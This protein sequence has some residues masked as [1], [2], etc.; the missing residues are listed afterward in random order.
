MKKFM[1]FIICFCLMGFGQILASEKATFIK[2]VEVKTQA[3]ELKIQLVANGPIS[4]YVFFN[5][6]KPTRLAIDVPLTDCKIPRIYPLNNPIYP[7]LRW[8]P[9][10]GKLRFVIDSN[11]KQLPPYKISAQNNKLEIFCLW[12]N[13]LYH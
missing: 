5:L 10:K 4:D 13:L 8:A 1:C 3:K 7:R 2:E 9:F 12:K 6:T 11:L